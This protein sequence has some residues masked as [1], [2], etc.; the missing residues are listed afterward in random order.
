MVTVT[1]E[2][3]I[4]I[5]AGLVAFAE[6]IAILLIWS[7]AGPCR[8]Y[9]LASISREK[10]NLLLI[11]RSDGSATLRR[12]FNEDGRY[13]AFLDNKMHEWIQVEPSGL[14]FGELQLQIVHDAYGIVT[15]PEKALV[16]E[17]VKKKYGVRNLRELMS[18]IK[19][20][21]SPNGTPVSGSDTIE[22][23]GVRPVDLQ[24]VAYWSGMTSR[25]RGQSLEAT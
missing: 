17:A 11:T 14:R 5:A 13:R 20:G 16:I 9:I 19:E 7:K 2:L 21:E 4:A 15:D 23:P 25:S 6:L 18:S 10:P 3:I 12:A 24:S 1:C 8:E 22:V